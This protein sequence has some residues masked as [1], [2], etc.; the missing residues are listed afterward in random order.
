MSALV[1]EVK[2]ENFEELVL[3]SNLPVVVDF[4]A[5]W[6]GPCRALAPKLE[7]YAEKLQGK[8]RFLK[9][10]VDENRQTTENYQIQS[11]PT[12]M[13]FVNGNWVAIS[14]GFGQP[15]LRLLDRLVETYK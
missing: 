5:P 7:E 4:W 11:I 8:V 14:L 6:C 10:N 13:V 15:T 1:Q 9:L 2:D 3:K 12:V